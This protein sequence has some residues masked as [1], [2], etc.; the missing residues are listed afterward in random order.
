M[1]IVNVAII[2][3]G[4]VGGGTYDLLTKNH[5]KILASYGIDVR[6]K[7]VLDKDKINHFYISRTQYTFLN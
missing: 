2:G 7:K 5:D 1:K 4:T 6:I 3:I